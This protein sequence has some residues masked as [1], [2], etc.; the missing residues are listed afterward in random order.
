MVKVKL[1]FP[2]RDKQYILAHLDSF[3]WDFSQY[4]LIYLQSRDNKIKMRY[5]GYSIINGDPVL[6]LTLE[7]E[8]Y[9]N[10]EQIAQIVHDNISIERINVNS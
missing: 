8:R 1:L 10:I 3:E 9:H 2:I 6:M 7:D 5:I 4:G